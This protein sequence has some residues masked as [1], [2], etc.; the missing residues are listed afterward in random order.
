MVAGSVAQSMVSF[1]VSRCDPIGIILS[2]SILDTNVISPPLLMLDNSFA[3]YYGYV[4]L[5]GILRVG[6][7]QKTREIEGKGF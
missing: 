3:G 6:N 1:L 4:R 5:C 7:M 2:M